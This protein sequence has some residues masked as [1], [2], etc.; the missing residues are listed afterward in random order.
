MDEALEIDRPAGGG[1]RIAVEV[2]FQYIRRGHQRGRH[3]AGE[4]QAIGALVVAHAHMPERIDHVLIVKDMV[5]LHQVGDQARIRGVYV[6]YRPRRWT[7]APRRPP[8][9]DR[10]S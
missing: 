3:A 8:A 10:T 2:E 4:Q 9:M 6:R 1:D 5:C 7:P